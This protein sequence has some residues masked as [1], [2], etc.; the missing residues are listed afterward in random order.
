[1]ASQ[2]SCKNGACPIDKKVD[3]INEKKHAVERNK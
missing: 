2:L 1:M 3:E